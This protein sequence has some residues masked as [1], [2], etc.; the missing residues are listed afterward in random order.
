MRAVSARRCPYSFTPGP[1]LR[2]PSLPASNA[3]TAA[4]S[5]FAC[6]RDER[7]AAPRAQR[8][9]FTALR[10]LSAQC[11]A[12]GFAFSLRRAPRG[13]RRAR[14]FR[15]RQGMRRAADSHAVATGRARTPARAVENARGCCRDPCGR[16]AFPRAPR[17]RPRRCDA[18]P[19]SVLRH[20]PTVARCNA[21]AAPRRRWR[22][23]GR[24]W[25]ARAC[26]TEA[27]AEKGCPAEG[28][29]RRATA[30][31]RRG[32]RGT[33][34][35]VCRCC[36]PS[37]PPRRRLA[38]AA[39]AIIR[40]RLVVASA[41]SSA[42][43]WAPSAALPRIAAGWTHPCPPSPPS[44]SRRARR[45]WEK[46]RGRPRVGARP[47]AHPS[48][49]PPSPRPAAVRAEAAPARRGSHSRCRTI[50]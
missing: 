32:R 15:Q 23:G 10:A 42:L 28:R 1:S 35:Q 8:S 3:S 50:A 18:S 19:A 37:P 49:H 39:R 43:C 36:W 5:P 47:L 34:L 44:P 17:G 40:G 25:H 21:R 26:P 2:S 9:R 41:S 12:S 14:R 30:T 11:A 16:F 24:A 13:A 22:W 38:V 4:L 6:G 46:K 27:S 45:T 20:G 31:R 48:G 7:R 33:A 29:A